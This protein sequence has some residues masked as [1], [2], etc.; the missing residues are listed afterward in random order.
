MNKNIIN[1]GSIQNNIIDP[2]PFTSILVEY[3]KDYLFEKL[4]NLRPMAQRV[5]YEMVKRGYRKANVYHLHSNN[6][7]L[8]IEHVFEDGLAFLPIHR[9]KGYSGF[10]HTHEYTENLDQNSVIFGVVAQNLENAKLFRDYHKGGNIDHKQIG[11]LLGYPDCCSQS[12]TPYFKKS[13]DP[14]WE[15]A[16]ATESSYEKNRILYVPHYDP[17]LL[18][19]LRYFGCRVISWFP[20]NFLCETSIRLSKI[21]F[22]IFKEVSEESAVFVKE[23]LEVKGQTWDLYNGQVS[24]K[25]PN[26]LWCIAGSYYTPKKRIIQFGE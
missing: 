14:I 17:L 7:D 10:A 24:I 8:E 11:D 12:F 2:N 18:Q 25:I 5:E 1:N 6:Y 15:I 23:L 22:N 26:Y 20:C 16:Q 21:W 4:Q 19:H 3:K 13:S 9:I